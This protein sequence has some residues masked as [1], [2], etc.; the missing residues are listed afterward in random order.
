[1]LD[2][3]TSASFTAGT[4]VTGYTALNVGNVT[5]LNITGLTNNTTYHYRVRAVYS[6][7]TSNVSIRIQLTTTAF[8]GPVAQPATAISCNG[9]TANWSAIAGA[10][11]YV[12]DVATT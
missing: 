7:G 4:F 11:S 2:V 10:T 9:F 6:C 1:M 5:S 12:I 3:A 8:S